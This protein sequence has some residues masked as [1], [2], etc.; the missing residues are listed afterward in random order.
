MEWFF[1]IPLTGN[2]PLFFRLCLFW[3]MHFLAWADL[4]VGNGLGHGLEFLTTMSIL[5]EKARDAK[6]LQSKAFHFVSCKGTPVV[7]ETPGKKKVAAEP[8]LLIETWG[9]P[10]LFLCPR[11]FSSMRHRHRR[12]GKKEEMLMRRVQ[13]ETGTRRKYCVEMESPLEDTSTIAC[14]CLY[15]IMLNLCSCHC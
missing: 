11:C 12:Y 9:R 15:Y 8:F 1:R 5:Q 6:G 4:R 10:L 7:G 13:D 14:S 3:E 2:T